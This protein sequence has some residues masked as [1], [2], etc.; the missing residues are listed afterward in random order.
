VFAQGDALKQMIA[1]KE[2]R[3]GIPQDGKH[4]VK[5][6]KKGGEVRSEADQVIVVIH[7]VE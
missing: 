4:E 3:N 7:N 1:E 5:S 6:I 2:R